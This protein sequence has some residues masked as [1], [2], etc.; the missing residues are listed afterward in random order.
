[1]KW[2]PT[3][4]WKLFDLFI[5]L[6]QTLIFALLTIRYFGFAAGSHEE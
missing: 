1:M 2:L 5:G 3:T 4:A 6:L